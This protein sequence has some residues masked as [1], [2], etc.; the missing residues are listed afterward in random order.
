M[1]QPDGRIVHC[2]FE[3][4]AARSAEG[5]IEPGIA[6]RWD[7][8][9]DGRT[10][11]FHLRQSVWSNG[12]P[13]VAQDF[14]RGWR[15]V[16][17]PETGA[18][19]AELFFFIEGAKEYLSE[20]AKLDKA[21]R[22]ELFRKVGIRVIDDRTLEVRLND[23]TPFF[24]Q[25]C[26]NPCYMPLH[27]NMIPK[28]G[29]MWTRP[30]NLIGNGAYTLAEWRLADRFV[31]KAN[32]KYW[33]APLP[34][35]KTVH[36]L[37]IKDAST[38]FNLFYSGKADLLIDKGLIPAQ[39][40]PKIA[41]KPWFNTNPF[42]ATYF[43]RFNVLRKPLDDARV[44][45]ALTMSID[46]A[47]IVKNLT[48][49]GE[50]TA[51]S[52]VPVGMP[53]YT[54]PQGLRYDVEA[55]KKLLAEAG[56]PNGEGFPPLKLLYNEAELNEAIA[57]AIQAMWKRNLNIDITLRKQDWNAYL[58]SL[59]K[60]DYDIGR[61]SWVGDYQDATTFT[62]MFVSGG[63]NNRTGYA[64]SE[65]D[66]LQAEAAREPDVARRAALIKEMEVLLVEKDVPIAPIYFFVG[67]TLYHRD[68]LGGFFPNQVDE[69]PIKFLYWKNSSER[70]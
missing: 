39:I 21:A 59:K 23:P 70:K 25:L 64:S 42:L 6:E 51:G 26:V 60:L 29:S 49:A 37:S 62:D 67:I 27:P 16:I 44:R 52:L 48:R 50:P 54:S 30:E 45:K 68:K 43:Y 15:R 36:A 46:K 31:L 13:V 40:I 53:G 55:A 65:Y 12:D 11:T 5:D 22:E 66:R 28:F 69:H 8:S 2:L 17:E 41:D 57:T 10:Y 4:L 63:G 20:A 34:A 61:S 7:I 9:P 19:Y 3:G 33:R 14:A 56:F 47:A 38:A 32:P 35:F 1:G 18:S 24:P 58:D